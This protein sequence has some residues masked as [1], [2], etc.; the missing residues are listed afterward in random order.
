MIKNKIQTLV[1][2]IFFSLNWTNYAQA[3][4][5]PGSASAIITAILGFIAA[6]GFTV[7]NY[8]HKIKSFFSKK[9]K[10]DELEKKFEEKS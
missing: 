3:Y 1:L 7:K 6:A 9:D 8:F 2:I 10:K 4:I 5:D